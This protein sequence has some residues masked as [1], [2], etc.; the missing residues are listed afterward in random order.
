MIVLTLATLAR[1]LISGS[2]RQQA[3]LSGAPVLPP[4][5]QYYSPEQ[6]AQFMQ[7]AQATS[8][9]VFIYIF[10]AILALLGVWVGWLLVGG[11]L[12]LVV[13]MFGG[14]GETSYSINLVAWAGLPFAIREL[15]R[16]GAMLATRQLIDAPG[17]S[18][19]APVDPSGTATYLAA[20]LSLVDIYLIWHMLLLIIGV[21]LGNSLSLVKAASGVIITLGIVVGVEALL[22]YLVG[23]LGSLTI[24]RPF[25]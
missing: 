2:I 18:G 16:A 13:T 12:H 21:K 23:K 10:P 8:G 6:Q 14:R 15:V 11:L 24:I 25:F 22:A 5:F 9:P 1:V 4:D 19:F 7:A 3:A 17:L 20:L